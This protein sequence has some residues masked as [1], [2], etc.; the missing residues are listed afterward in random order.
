MGRRSRQ[1]SEFLRELHSP[2]LKERSK[3]VMGFLVLNDSEWNSEDDS[4]Y[5]QRTAE[6]GIFFHASSKPE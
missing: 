1:E 2:R 4:S 3:G 5:A 6:P